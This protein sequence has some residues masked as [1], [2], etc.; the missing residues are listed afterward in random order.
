MLTII[1]EERFLGAAIATSLVFLLFGDRIHSDY[2]NPFYLTLVLAWLFFVIL[3]SVLAVVRH[4]D[5]LAERLGEPYGTLVLTLAVTAIEAMSISA[6]MLHGANN[7]TLVR[8]T[9]MGVIMIILNGMVGVSLLAGGWRHREQQYNLQGANAYLCVIIPLAVLGLVL[10]NTTQ[11][12]AGPT[13]SGMQ[14]T[15]L[16]IMS[17]CLYAAFLVI[18]TGRHRGFFVLEAEGLPHHAEGGSLWKHVFFLAAYMLP[19][20]FLAEHLAPPTDYVIE[21]LKAPVALGGLA[22]AVLVATP[23][24]IGATKAAFNNHLQRAM[25]IFLGSVLATIGLTI[26]AMLLIGRL[27]GHTIFLGVEHGNQVLLLLTLFL[28]AI[29]FTSGRT[30][31]LQGLVHVLLFFAYILLIFEG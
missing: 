31:I 1:R 16:S 13:L 6:V 15:F 17:I 28:S 3:G 26:P 9:L 25:N 12:T 23:E 24:A 27:T 30:N 5:Q 29:T 8:D 7:P 11:T 14:E 21:T 19:V 18:Q 10:P 20:V 4:A 2:S 22:I